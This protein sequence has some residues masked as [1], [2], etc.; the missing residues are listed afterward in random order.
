MSNM[1][2]NEEDIE[3]QDTTEKTP[4]LESIE[5]NKSETDSKK[6]KS[7]TDSK[8]EKTETNS[9]KGKTETYL[10]TISNNK[11]FSGCVVFNVVL[12]ISILIVTIAW[13]MFVQTKIVDFD[14]APDLYCIDCNNVDSKDVK[15]FSSNDGDRC[16]ADKNGKFLEYIM[17]KVRPIHG[18][19][20]FHT[21]C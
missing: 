12:I 2:T 21:L 13:L 16:C 8:K 1:A 14:A 5:K 10:A 17:S 6:E 20:Y 11:L 7:E 19:F 18:N 9:K 3:L 15:R 4:A